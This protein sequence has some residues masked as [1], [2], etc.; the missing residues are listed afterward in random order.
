MNRL[1]PF[2]SFTRYNVPQQFSNI[3]TRPG[4]LGAT[5]LKEI[6]RLRNED[7][8]FMPEYLG[9][10]LGLPLGEEKEGTR[11]YLTKLDTPV[12]AAFDWIGM[13]PEIGKG[14]LGIT[15]DTGMRALGMLNP[16]LKLPLEL[17][18]QKQFF[19]GRDLDTLYSR[20]GLPTWMEQIIMN[21]PASRLFTTGGQFFDP[22]KDLQAMLINTLTGARVSDIDVEKWREIEGRQKIKEMLRGR[23]GVGVFEKLYPRDIEQLTPEDIELLRLDRILGEHAKRRAME[24]R[25][26]Q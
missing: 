18:T 25:M 21:S 10:G 22:R 15:T 13:R 7:A 6:A 12:E 1:M 11:R 8:G 9:G 23:P 19:T 24:R 4:G 16:L 5:L 20:T 17:A 26:A 2:Y 14:S 3:T